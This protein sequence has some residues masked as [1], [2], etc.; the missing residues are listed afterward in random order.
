MPVKYPYL[1]YLYILDE[2]LP[3]TILTSIFFH[4]I[5]VLF[6]AIIEIINLSELQ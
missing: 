1:I 2:V 4:T 3:I 6:L 5:F